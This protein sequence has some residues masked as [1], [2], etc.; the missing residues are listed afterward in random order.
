MSFQKGCTQRTPLTA[1]HPARVAGCEEG[2]NPSHP[3]AF[4]REED[5]VRHSH[6]GVQKALSKVRD[7]RETERDRERQRRETCLE[8]DERERE[9]EREREESYLHR[10]RDDR[11][12][13]R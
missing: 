13:E 10:E 4:T 5:A 3:D 2:V 1:T 12:R 7:D 9:R 8:T 11:E 6:E